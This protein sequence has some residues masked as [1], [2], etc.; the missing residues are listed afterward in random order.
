MTTITHCPECGAP[1]TDGLNCFDM[2]GVVLSWE[3]FDQDLLNLHFWTVATYNLQH[4]AQFTE[5]AIK[6]LREVYLEAYEKEVP[7]SYIRKKMSRL[8]EGKVHVIKKVNIT[9]CLK[10]WPIT[11]ADIYH[12]NQHIGV[13]HRV[14]QW[15]KS[16]R[17][18]L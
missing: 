9:P 17:S 7:I 8:T 4:P 18:A 15:R 16:V 5:E 10:S 6:G 3:A 13:S 2:F 12:H 14:L 1:Q 11:I